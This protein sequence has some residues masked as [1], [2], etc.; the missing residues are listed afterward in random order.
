M[1]FSRFK[2]LWSTV[3][4]D[5]QYR[6]LGW[7]PGTYFWNFY[8]G[9]LR[10]HLPGQPGALKRFRC[11]HGITGRTLD[12]FLRIDPGCSD[13]V[14]LQ[15]VWVHQD[16]YHRAFEGAKTVLDIGGNIGLS[17]LWFSDWL[18]PTGYACL[19]PDPRNLK[20]LR[21]N[22]EVNGL[23]VRIFECAATAQSGEFSFNLAEDHGCSAL[24]G[25]GI[26]DGLHEEKSVVT[27]NGRRVSSILD[28]LGWEKVDLVKID[29]EG[30]EKELLR[31][32]QG[33]IDRVGQIVMEI[34]A[35]TS[36]E[37]IQS[38]LPSPWVLERLGTQEEPT[39]R[40]F[41]KS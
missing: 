19:E 14:A 16:Y 22:I 36:P 20:M 5:G 9:R 40:A 35:N 38:F 27:V 29:I 8:Q 15:G 23:K 1:A 33:W 31:N 17:T 10:D 30:G 7:W 34:H 2:R 41:R 26:K 13:F 24:Q 28:E 6:R 12:I 4:L 25:V 37:E 32:C 18:Q 11:K 3:R 39:F 21:K